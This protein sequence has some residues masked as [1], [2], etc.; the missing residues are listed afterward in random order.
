VLI[1]KAAIVQAFD[2]LGE[3]DL[4]DDARRLLPEQLDTEQHL[5]LFLQFGID[6]RDLLSRLRRAQPGANTTIQRRVV[7]HEAPDPASTEA[8]KRERSSS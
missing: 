5:D 4:A 6:P 1:A 3:Y 8:P 2:E 7:R